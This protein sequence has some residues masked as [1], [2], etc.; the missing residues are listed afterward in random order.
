MCIR[1]SS[2]L[3]PDFVRG[4]MILSLLLSFIVGIVIA[5]FSG[6]SLAVSGWIAIAALLL[7]LLLFRW[8]GLAI[9]L[10]LALSLGMLTVSYTPLDVYKRQGPFT[11]E[12]VFPLGAGYCSHN[13]RQDDCP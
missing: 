5:E 7:S 10:P 2:K 1:Y 3:I 6:I 4:R 13:D 8:G 9:F 11:W 12:A